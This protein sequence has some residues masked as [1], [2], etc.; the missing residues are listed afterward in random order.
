MISSSSSSFDQSVKNTL[1]TVDGI[2]K[3]TT[4]QRDD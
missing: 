3:I 4:G 1:R 2:Q